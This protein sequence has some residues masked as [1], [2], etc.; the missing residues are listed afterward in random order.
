MSS[1]RLRWILGLGLVF[2]LVLVTNLVDRTNFRGVSEAI[3]NIY[4]DRLVAKG[5]IY[6]MRS[7]LATK[8]VA[9]AAADDAYRQDGYRKDADAM[10]SLIAA[11]EDTELTTAEEVAFAS[12]QRRYQTLHDLE[13]ELAAVPG[14]LDP[15]ARTQLR[16]AHD[17]V[18]AELFVLSRIQLTEGNRE[19]FIAAQALQ[20]VEVLTKIEM[21]LLVT[22][23]AVLLLL[24]VSWPRE[25]A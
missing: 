24:I 7:I 17:A 10:R 4:E 14:A 16:A 22:L 18:V 1:I 19:R 20:S 11:F 2:T 12:L 3:T 8:Q 6:D 13:G 23:G 5:L 25:Q 21:V 15:V 9:L